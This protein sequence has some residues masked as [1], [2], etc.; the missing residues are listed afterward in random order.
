VDSNKVHPTSNTLNTT[1]YFDGVEDDIHARASEPS[2][3]D[4]TDDDVSGDLVLEHQH[5]QSPGQ[6][7][8]LDSENPEIGVEIGHFQNRSDA[9]AV[10]ARQ[11][12]GSGWNEK[13]SP[14]GDDFDTDDVELKRV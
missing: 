10:W 6:V 2:T 13:S 7:F 9:W 12:A 8:L 1:V 11:F 3:H 14:V 4:I 5:Y